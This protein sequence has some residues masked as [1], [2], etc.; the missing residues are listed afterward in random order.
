MD[1]YRSRP[2]AA[3]VLVAGMV[4]GIFMAGVTPVRARAITPST[5]SSTGPMAPTTT[6]PSRLP[7]PQ[8]TL[9]P[10]TTGA[11]PDQRPD[12]VASPDPTITAEQVR[13]GIELGRLTERIR[14]VAD[15][16]ATAQAE[17]DSLQ[18][19]I[20][21]I[22]EQ[23]VALEARVAEVHSRIQARLRAVYQ[24]SSTGPLA[25][26]DLGTVQDLGAGR[27]YADVTV[28]VD[29]REVERLSGL[30]SELA[31]QRMRRSELRSGLEAATRSLAAERQRLEQLRDDQGQFLEQWG[32]LTVLGPPILTADQI[33]DW[34]A[35]TG[36]RPQLTDAMSI[37]DL[38]QLFL[39]EGRIHS[40]RGD[41]AFAQSVI[42]TGNFTEYSFNN[43]SGI[44]WCDSCT[45]GHRFETPAA[46]VR[47]QVQL[48]RDYA[49]ASGRATDI[50]VPLSPALFGWD[51][52][53]AAQHYDTFFLKG[54]V[55]FWSQMGRGNWATDPFYAGKVLGVYARMLA[56]AARQSR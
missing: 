14:A 26:L 37:R 3:G 21:R 40:V 36:V 20:D 33:A 51:P 38:A 27:V 16:Y 41:V 12:D 22:T 55:V 53:T 49:D 4:V 10:P 46:G 25:V 47:A 32:D 31:N 44:G 11:S 6:I 42:E 7:A 35:S 8:P 18:R 48:L 54:K 50:P 17:Q 56:F 39:D 13:A 28:A 9:A 1:G 19:E 34:F 24:R 30:Q 5:T 29:Q 2:A 15:S 52:T 43:Y 45:T 23:V